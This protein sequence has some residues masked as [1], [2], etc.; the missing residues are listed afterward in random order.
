MNRKILT[1]TAVVVA[2]TIVSGIA[3]AVFFHR[4][5][6][7]DAME[8]MARQ[9][10]VTAS[11]IEEDLEDLRF[12]PGNNPGEQIL[13]GRSQLN[14][15]LERARSVGGHDT[16]EAV[17]AIRERVLPITESLEMMP[18]IPA[19]TQEGTVQEVEVDGES[20]LVAIER[21]EL[22]EGTLVVAFGRTSPLFPTSQVVVALLLALAIGSILTIGLGVWFTRSLSLRLANVA[23]TARKVGEGDLSARADVV[24][25]DEIASVAVAVNDMASDLERSR[26][27]EREFLMDVG[28]DLRTPLTTIRGYAEA[29]DSGAVPPAELSTVAA[30]MNRQT[31][32]LSRLVEDVTLLARLETREFTFRPEAVDVSL[33]VFGIAESYRVR[34]DAESIALR[35]DDSSGAPVVADADR[36]AQIV[37]NLMDNALRY[38]PDGGVISV[39]VSSIGQTVHIAVSNTGPIISSD[40]LPHIF[41]RLYAADRYRSERPSGSGLGLAIVKELASAMGGTVS[42]T[43]DHS[44]G[45]TF[46][47]VFDATAPIEQ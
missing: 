34:A 42:A 44:T 35:F 19:S 12:A 3:I 5:L 14:R 11:L 47:V 17:F 31:D 15:S 13:R 1:A 43:S 37:G 10:R 24:G 40:D 41:E 6:Q 27:R 26:R 25:S 45:T 20:V 29:L 21:V 46:D 18:E 30:A 7:A 28:H 39:G 2:I 38:T 8:E 9:T 22:N 23:N 33:I 36:L 16:V 4:E 32:Q